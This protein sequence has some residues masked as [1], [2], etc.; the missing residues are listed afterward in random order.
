VVRAP[1][2]LTVTLARPAS[3]FAK[4]EVRTDRLRQAQKQAC[5]QWT[6]GRLPISLFFEVTPLKFPVPLL[7][8]FHRN[9][10]IWQAFLMRL[11]AN[12]L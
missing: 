8:E 11:K 10:R 2:A 6:L 12:S 5:K 3:V 7:R 9:R 4:R 1:K